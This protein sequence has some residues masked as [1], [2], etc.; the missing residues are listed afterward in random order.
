MKFSA[1]V[2]NKYLTINQLHKN[3]SD[4]NENSSVF[5]SILTRRLIL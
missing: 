1:D 5:L 4:S 3:N 2:P